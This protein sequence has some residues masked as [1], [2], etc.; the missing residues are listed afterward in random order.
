MKRWLATS[1]ALG[2]AGAGQAAPPNFTPPSQFAGGA[3]LS[4]KDTAEALEAFRAAGP[5]Q[6]SYLEFALR[7]MPRRGEE[8]VLRGRLWVSR[9]E[10]GAVYRIDIDG[11]AHFLLQNGPEARVWRAAPGAAAAIVP[12][13]DPLAPGLEITAFDL[14]RPYLYWPLA[15]PVGVVRQRGRPA[16]VFVFRNPAGGPIALVRAYLD[17]EYHAPV[18]VES[19]DSHGTI[20][21]TFSLLDLKKLSGQWLPKDIDARDEVSHSKTRFS[22]TGAALGLDLSQSLFEPSALGENPSPPP[23]VQRFD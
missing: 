18:D 23:G 16:D 6:P 10:A 13:S 4:D 20:L 5:A 22:L 7:H 3:T 15:G 17:S 21:R 19:L 8:T 14:Q 12:A 9:D 2:L 11:G 1:V